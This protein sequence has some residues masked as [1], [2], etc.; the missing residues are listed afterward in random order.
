[1]T[2]G[3]TA[4]MWRWAGQLL[5][6]PSEIIIFASD[7]TKF[8][9][10]VDEA[11]PSRLLLQPVGGRGL[12]VLETRIP[13]VGAMAGGWVVNGW[14]AGWRCGWGCGTGRLGGAARGLRVVVRLMGFWVGWLR[15]RG[16]YWGRAGAATC[17][18]PVRWLSLGPI[19][20]SFSHSLPV[21]SSN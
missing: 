7:G 17:A 9:A 4:V 16:A 6:V 2:A 18:T 21:S 11:R 15:A 19:M 1:M 13:E 12:Y 10:K 5:A 3:F 14:G 8:L 20:H